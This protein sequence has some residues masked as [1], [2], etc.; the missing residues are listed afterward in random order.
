MYPKTLYVVRHGATAANEQRPKIMQGKGIDQPLSQTGRSQA[1][2]LAEFLRS[3]EIEQI[4][5]SP[6]RRA[7]ET[8]EIV[9]QSKQLPVE[10][11][12]RLHEVDVGLWEGRSWDWVRRQSGAAYRRFLDSPD[13]AGYPGG[14]SYSDVLARVG[15]AMED[16]PRPDV[17][18]V[19]VVGHSV[20]NRVF[21][22]SVLGLAL[23][24]ARRIPQQNCC[25]NVID[26]ASTSTGL[27]T[28]NIKTLNSV[29][30]L[31]RSGNYGSA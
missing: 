6:M 29:F 14:E 21:L 15:P 4:I 9:A 24:H 10:I 26:C 13:Q 3:I 12:P 19:L 5:S 20:V 30:H 22:A 1:R 25:I 7:I 16:R 31:D 2:A 28:M 11:E 27:I 8:A 17:S 18:R 23:K